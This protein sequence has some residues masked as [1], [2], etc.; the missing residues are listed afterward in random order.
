M[1]IWVASFNQILIILVFLHLLFLCFEIGHFLIIWCQRLI[2]FIVVFKFN[3][4]W[5]WSLVLEVVCECFLYLSI[6]PLALLVWMICKRFTYSFKLMWWTYMT[7]DQ[8]QPNVTN[9][10][11]RDICLVQHF[12]HKMWNKKKLNQ[13]DVVIPM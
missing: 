12:K 6:V 5:T 7:W 4:W 9:G 3:V 13:L 2:S 11:T 1:H 8:T 10:I